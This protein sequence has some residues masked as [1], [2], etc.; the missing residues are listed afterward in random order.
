MPDSEYQAG[1]RPHRDGA[2]TRF[3]ANRSAPSA[4]A[5]RMRRLSRRRH[6]GRQVTP[7]N[8]EQAAVSRNQ[9]Q[10]TGFEHRGVWGRQHL[11]RAKPVVGHH[12]QQQRDNAARDNR[13]DVADECSGLRRGGRRS[14]GHCSDSSAASLNRP[15]PCPRV[16]R[17]RVPVR[18]EVRVRRE[19]RGLSRGPA[20]RP[21]WQPPWS[22][23]RC[24]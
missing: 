9:E 19:W 14:L 15:S 4:N 21:T 24:Q 10:R 17:E 8:R 6:P 22:R 3:I 23:P 13:N 7:E 2:P 1:T 20:R 16:P 12:G 5:Y 11:M 18:A